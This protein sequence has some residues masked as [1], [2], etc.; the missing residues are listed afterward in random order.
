MKG[1]RKTQFAATMEATAVTCP[2]KAKILQPLPQ[3]HTFPFRRRPSLQNSTSCLL[4][5][6]ETILIFANKFR[7]SGWAGGQTVSGA[8]DRKWREGRLR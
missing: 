1:N 3:L 7:P 6:G 8:N 5:S 4:A 2:A